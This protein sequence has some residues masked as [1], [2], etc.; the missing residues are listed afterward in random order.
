MPS[1]GTL[2]PGTLSHYTASCTQS[3]HWGCKELL[4]PV[5]HFDSENVGWIQLTCWFLKF[6]TKKQQM[7]TKYIQ[8][9]IEVFFLGFQM[10]NVWFFIIF[11][12]INK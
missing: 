3:E 8:G 5:I 10:H 1:L 7:K 11:F 2:G 6:T 12:E 9:K 4:L